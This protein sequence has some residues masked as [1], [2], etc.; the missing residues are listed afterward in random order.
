MVVKGRGVLAG[1]F[2]GAGSVF[3]RAGGRFPARSRRLRRPW[4]ALLTLELQGSQDRGLQGTC[5]RWLSKGN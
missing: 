4:A 3:Q 5:F 2:Q 1:L